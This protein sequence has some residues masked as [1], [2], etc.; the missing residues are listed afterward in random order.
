VPYS[1]RSLVRATTGRGSL[2]AS[3]LAAAGTQYPDWVR[4]YLDIR[5]D[6]ISDE[7]YATARSIRASVRATERD[8]Y[9]VALAVQ[10]Y[11]YA[12]GDFTYST[13][14][15]GECGGE[16]L[17]D[18]FLRIRKGYCE[19]FATAMVMMLRALDIP[20]RYVLGYL[21]GQEQDD[22]TWRVDRG[23]AHAWVEVY[24]PSFGWVEF[25]PTPGNAENGQAPTRL[26][27][28]GPAPSGDPDSDSPQFPGQGELECIDVN[29]ENTDDDTIPPQ[30]APAAPTSESLLP[31]ALVAGMVLVAA[32]LAL[33]AAL[34]RIPS[35][36][37]EL[38]YSGIARLA[39]RLGYGPRPGQT[40]YEYAA[41]L[42]ELVPVARPDLELL[43]TAKVEATYGRRQPGS[44]LLLRIGVAYR[45]A[46]M[47]LLRLLFR[48]PRFGRG[49][50]TPGAPRV[51]VRR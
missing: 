26:P 43:A 27:V 19:Y 8:P 15:R 36:Q 5:P 48:R 23:A 30:A 42:G 2:T 41:R 11:L 20:A 33:W 51:R 46:R 21:P 44:V 14:I 13:D 18:C 7:V 49:P 38:A 17:I 16:K 28:G 35:T 47:G 1:V 45:R 31:L 50:R 3:Q 10:D 40:A 29:C 34:R 9:H 24:F 32:A 12:S 6:S 39:T 25:D 4:P 22:G 37:P